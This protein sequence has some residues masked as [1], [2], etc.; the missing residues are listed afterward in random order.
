[1]APFELHI[2]AYWYGGGGLYFN[3]HC[4][5]FDVDC[6]EDYVFIYTDESRYRNLCFPKD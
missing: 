2:A 4:D 1:M 3:P 6:N 5:C